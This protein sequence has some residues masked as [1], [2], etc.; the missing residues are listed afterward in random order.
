MKQANLEEVV[1]QRLIKLTPRRLALV[2]GIVVALAGVGVAEA[3]TSTPVSFDCQADAIHVT[4]LGPTLD[5][6]LA[7][8]AET[9]CSSQS[10][11]VGPLS[12]SDAAQLNAA[13]SVGS[14]SAQTTASANASA[15]TST[16]DVPSFVGA[17]NGI[18]VTRVISNAAEVCVNGAATPSASSKVFGL[19]VNGTAYGNVSGAQTINVP[20]VG[21]LHVNSTTNATGAITAQALVLDVL[22]SVPNIGGAQIVLGQATASAGNCPTPVNGAAGSGLGVASGVGGTLASREAASALA[23]GCSAR[24]LVLIDVLQHDGRVSLLGA[25]APDLVGDQVAIRYAASG[26]IVAKAVVGEDGFFGTTAPLPAASVRDTN[27]ARYQASIDGQS[28]LDLKLTRRMIV[29]SISSA[30]GS[31][32]IRGRVVGPLADPI[33]KIYVER[34]VSCTSKVQVK[35]LL[36]AAN[37]TFSVTLAAPTDSQAAEYRAV[38]RVRLDTASAKTY[39]T[40]TLPRVVSW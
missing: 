13:L 38:T 40:A 2:G 12:A 36:P 3:A 15:A 23:L 7:N 24:K 16:V 4:G 11:P 20:N 31:V 19:T 32:T 1:M 8:A 5:A 30:N 29:Q 10:I 26:K 21:T 18:H 35:G 34:E 9:P 33:A 17:L 22:P 25:A 27:R 28:S 39:P 37:G 6:A 14:V